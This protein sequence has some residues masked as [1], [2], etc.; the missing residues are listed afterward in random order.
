MYL[1][2]S[3][4][5]VISKSESNSVVQSKKRQIIMKVCTIIRC[6]I[7]AP[8]IV[9]SPTSTALHI[10]VPLLNHILVS[11][12]RHRFISSLNIH[13]VILPPPSTHLT[14]I[15]RYFSPISQ[16]EQDSVLTSSSLHPLF[17]HRPQYPCQDYVLSVSPIQKRGHCN[18]DSGMR[19]MVISWRC[20]SSFLLC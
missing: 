6:H 7:S 1:I 14:K 20:V 11:G 9:S 19:F 3:I 17:S 10:V 13:T 4:Q 16:D 5:S 2:L 15:L 8:F 12:R 18:N